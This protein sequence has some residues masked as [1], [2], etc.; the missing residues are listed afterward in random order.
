MSVIDELSNDELQKQIIRRNIALDSLKNAKKALNSGQKE[1]NNM[2]KDGCH[3]GNTYYLSD[4]FV[5][6]MNEIHNMIETIQ[7]GD[8]CFS[9]QATKKR[10]EEMD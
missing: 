1:Y 9:V 5:K 10:E 4:G 3:L 8:W 6:V 7:S 2:M